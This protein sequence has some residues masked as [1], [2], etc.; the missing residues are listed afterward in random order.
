MPSNHNNKFSTFFQQN[1][2]EIFNILCF[3]AS[4]IMLV[5]TL[6]PTNYPIVGHDFQYHYLRVE[7]VKYNIET[8]NLFS[9]IDYFYFGGGGYAGFAY[10]ELFLY[11]PALL[12]IIGFSIGDSMA[13]LLILCNAFS[14]CFM[15]LFLKNVSDSPICGTLGAVLYVLS[16]YRLDNII[17]RFA[18]GEV[19]A[20]VFYPLILWGL[21]DF[22]FGE[23]KK[24]Y[25]LGIGFVGMLLSHTI[26]TV[27][28]LG[29][30]VIVSLIFIKRV[31]QQKNRLP[32][33]FITAGICVLVTAYY[34]LPLLELLN[35]CE[36][37]VKIS[38]YHTVDYDIPFMSLF[39]DEMHNGIAGLRFPIFLF[40]LPRI[41]LTK[42]SPAYKEYFQ[43][44]NAQKRRNILL[45]AD[46]FLILGLVFAV[47]STDI[48]PWEFLS[49]FMDFIQF[50]WRFF[51]L[52]SIFLTIAGTVYVFSV[53]E[54][55]KAS[56]KTVAA[57]TA[58]AIFIAS[59]HVVIGGVGHDKSFTANHYDNV[60]ETYHIGMGEW[61]PR[62]ANENGKNVLKKMGNSVVLSNNEWIFCKRENGKLSFELPEYSN[63]E[64]AELPF[65]WY[66]GYEAYDENGRE[67][68]ISMSENGL[69][70][71]DIE[72]AVGTVNVRHKPT[73]LR[74][75]SY[76]VSAVTIVILAVAAVI[77]Y[78]RKKFAE[79]LI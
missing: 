2:T 7:A 67:L 62:A 50:P 9:G 27:L 11:I 23:F 3:L 36:M 45:L 51:A 72:N 61:L 65:I 6:I 22:I 76:F 71:V 18:L 12:R 59:Y 13:V 4:N 19:L 30:C 79:K 15:F 57:I 58:A 38:A 70:K 78:R 24:P 73:T 40:C 14:Y 74:M 32:R 68:E 1:S 37:S 16:T 77:F 60:E 44:E 46:V 48:A 53:S 26:S 21:W 29:V 34:W 54:Y 41:F 66:K 64:Y 17:T 5:I 55:L 33:L 10:P 8:G 63:A 49:K 25:L 42:N 47:L 52:V 56:K 75:I 43:G 20:F 28:A 69:V 31:L 35:S 39:R